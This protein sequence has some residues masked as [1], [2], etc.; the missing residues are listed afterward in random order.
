MLAELDRQHKQHLRATLIYPRK[1]AAV[2]KIKASQD[3]NTWHYH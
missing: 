2:A 1:E 3:D